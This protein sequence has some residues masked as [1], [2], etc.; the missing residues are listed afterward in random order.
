MILSVTRKIFESYLKKINKE[1]K[2]ISVTV[3]WT[4]AGPTGFEK[5]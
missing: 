2:D 1:D 5:K 3:G 4:Q